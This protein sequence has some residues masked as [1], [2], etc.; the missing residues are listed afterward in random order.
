MKNY[1]I[2]TSD[3]LASEIA[4]G[5]M[6]ITN[7]P[8]DNAIRIV[9]SAL[10]HQINF[11]DHAD[12]YSSGESE[13]L[14]LHRPD[15]LVEPEEVAE[16]FSILHKSGKVR[17]FGVS[18]QRPMQIE[19]LRKYVKQPIIANQLQLSIAHANMIGSGFYVNMGQEHADRD[20]SVLDYCRLHDITVQAW[21]PFQY[22]F[23]SGIFLDSSLYE[24][25]NSKLQEIAD[26]HHTTKTAI[27]IAWLQRHPA[28]IQTIVGTMNLKHLEEIC[29]ASDV[30][31]SRKEWYG[32]Y[33]SAGNDLP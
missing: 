9:R 32:I 3:I 25:L 30:S 11:F 14:L 2:G 5:C 20:G 15:A 12:I 29:A 7:T 33:L 19:L 22:G 18:N 1:L 24:D 27:A 4:L 21:S 23:F 31:L 16:A 8:Y 6:R 28:H 10:D 17:H 13:I 26:E